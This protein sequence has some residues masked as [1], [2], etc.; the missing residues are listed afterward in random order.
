MINHRALAIL[1][2]FIPSPLFS[3]DPFSTKYK[4]ALHSANILHPANVQHTLVYNSAYEL[5]FSDLV[6]AQSEVEE[7]V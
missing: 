6:F 2:I 1:A 7:R 3:S 4:D 5:D